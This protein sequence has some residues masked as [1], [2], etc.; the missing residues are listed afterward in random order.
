[1]YDGERVRG[2]LH[3]LAQ[4]VEQRRVSNSRMRVDVA[5]WSG[6]VAV[7]DMDAITEAAQTKPQEIPIRVARCSR[8]KHAKTANLCLPHHMQAVNSNRR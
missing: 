5:K 2:E 6:N 3:V 8:I 4:S 1:V 7:A